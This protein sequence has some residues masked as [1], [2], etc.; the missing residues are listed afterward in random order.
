MSKT[1][2]SARSDS[3]NGRSGR[4]RC[5]PLQE[6]KRAQRQEIGGSW[7]D[8]NAKAVVDENRNERDC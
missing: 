4:S 5:G 1:R 6:E 7:P 2:L 8:A 3:T